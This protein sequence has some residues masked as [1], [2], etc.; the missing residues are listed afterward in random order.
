MVALLTII[1]ILLVAWGIA[2]WSIGF[3]AAFLGLSLLAVAL[4]KV[5]L[6]QENKK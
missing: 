2:Q 5:A 3:A 1:G 4:T 6:D